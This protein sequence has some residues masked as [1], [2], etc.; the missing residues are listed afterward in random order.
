MI[1]TQTNNQSIHFFFCNSCSVFGKL[2]FNSIKWLELLSVATFVDCRKL[3]RR[4]RCISPL[5]CPVVDYDQSGVKVG[6]A[7]PKLLCILQEFRSS[8]GAALRRQ[9]AQ[10][11]I[12]LLT[13]LGGITRAGAR[14]LP[15]SFPPRGRLMKIYRGCS[16]DPPRSGYYV[17]LNQNGK[18]CVARGELE[19][20]STWFRNR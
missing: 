10:S 15:K 1:L 12:T 3:E 18:L 11:N 14:S 5:D 13:N 17:A 9:S 8:M 16:S 19:R 7:V 2:Y 4:G 20:F 6:E